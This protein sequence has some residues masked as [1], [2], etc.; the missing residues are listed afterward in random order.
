MDHPGFTNASEIPPDL[1]LILA[2]DKPIN[3]QW[4]IAEPQI[5]RVSR[6]K[7][8]RDIWAVDF[9][10]SPTPYDGIFLGYSDRGL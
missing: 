3:S 2:S 8:A 9:S 4:H 6:R 10:R 5:S 1:V 7:G